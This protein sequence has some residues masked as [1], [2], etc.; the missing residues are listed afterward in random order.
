VDLSGGKVFLGH[1][2]LQV[3]N[4]T[5]NWATRWLI[6]RRKIPYS[7][8]NPTQE[9]EL[10]EEFRIRCLIL[11]VDQLYPTCTDQVLVY[12]LGWTLRGEDG[13]RL[14]VVLTPMQW[15]AKEDLSQC[16]KVQVGLPTTYADFQD[17][18]D[19]CEFDTLPPCRIWDH[20]IELIE[21]AE[22]HLDCKIYPLSRID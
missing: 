1:D 20:M 14:R 6:F 7:D 15:L 10:T 4:P 19:K 8:L 5:I 21:G 17:I 12:A 22:P 18:F 2:W 9:D 11:Q 3:A 13:F 16:M